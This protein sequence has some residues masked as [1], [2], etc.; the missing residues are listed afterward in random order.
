MTSVE[1]WRPPAGW[2]P[3]PDRALTQRYWDGNA[4]TQHRTPSPPGAVPDSSDAQTDANTHRPERQQDDLAGPGARLGAVAID[5]VF[6]T[7][8]VFLLAFPGWAVGPIRGT[9]HGDSIALLSGLSMLIFIAAYYPLAEGRVGQSYGKHLLGIKVV[10]HHNR[11]VIG[12]A[13]AIARMLMRTLGVYALGLGVA[14][15]LWDERRQ[16]FHDKAV[17]SLVVRTRDERPDTPIE[18]LKAVFTPPRTTH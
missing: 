15:L 3:D 13:P 1:D 7:A 5:M 10:D 16:A 14:W 12:V 8:V 17:G 4:W 6:G 18:H 11:Q 9:V 2:Y